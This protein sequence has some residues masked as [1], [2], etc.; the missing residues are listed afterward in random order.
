MN[1]KKV[2][3]YITRGWD[4]ENPTIHPLLRIIP[5]IVLDLVFIL[6][7]VGALLKLIFWLFGIDE[8]TI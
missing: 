7:I 1:F 2:F 3:K 4:E 6:L 5:P 8:N